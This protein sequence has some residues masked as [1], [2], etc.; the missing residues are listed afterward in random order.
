MSELPFFVYGTLRPGAHNHDRFLRGRT[1][2]EE[3]ARLPC[4]RLHDGPGHPY[5]VRAADGEV[6]GDLVHAAPGA[7]A[8]LIAELDRLEDYFGPGHPLNLYTRETCEVVRVHDG[9]AV[10]AWVYLATARAGLGAPVA[11][12]DWFSRPRRPV[13]DAPR[14]P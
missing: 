2:A 4:A 5:A 1:A 11:G 8:G 13:P 14:T 7:Y 3:P 9:A 12:G 10:R 6:V